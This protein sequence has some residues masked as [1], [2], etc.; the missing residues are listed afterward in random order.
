MSPITDGRWLLVYQEGMAHT[1][2]DETPVRVRP[3]RPSDKAA[4][5]E[6]L[7]ELSDSSVHRRFLS[8]KP[9][10]TSSELRYLTEV[11]G[12]HHLALIAEDSGG[13][14]VGVGRWVRTEG[15]GVAEVAIVVADHLQG[16]G[17]GSLLADLLAGEAARHGV[18][19]FTAT[20]LSDNLAAHRLIVR[21][22]AQLERLRGAGALAA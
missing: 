13:R 4:M 8:P 9:R 19:R 7:G 20:T 17:L 12:H 5:A 2:R 10:F 14:I 3:I 15:G 21:L 22:D 16:L 1:L 18:R 6:A 11:D